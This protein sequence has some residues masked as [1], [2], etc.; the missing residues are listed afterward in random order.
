MWCIPQNPS[1]NSQAFKASNWELQLAISIPEFQRMPTYHTFLSMLEAMRNT[2]MFLQGKRGVNRNVVLRVENYSIHMWAQPSRRLMFSRH[3]VGWNIKFWRVWFTF[4]Q[5]NDPK[6]AIIATLEWL[7]GKQSKVL[8]WP[9]QNKT[10]LV[11]ITINI[12][13]I[14]KVLG[15]FCK[16][17]DAN[18][19]KIDFNFLQ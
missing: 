17:N 19:T 15:R 11:C 4:Q 12:F 13:C 9:S 18:P 7:K 10:F 6:H 5:D 1:F 8:E 3:W 16:S 2:K 14:F